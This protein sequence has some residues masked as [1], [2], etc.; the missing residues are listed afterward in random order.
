LPKNLDYE[1]VIPNSI[2]KDMDKLK[3]K[4]KKS[5]E[6][7]LKGL[8][9]IQ[10]NPYNSDVMQNYFKG[11]RKKRKGEYRIIFDIEHSTNPSEI[12]ILLI[13]HRKDIYK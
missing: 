9:E 1:L 4:N 3:K 2:L 6:K 8:E 7:I 10:K 13:G 11:C 12:H 5:A